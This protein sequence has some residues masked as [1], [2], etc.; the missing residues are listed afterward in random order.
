MEFM[1][2]AIDGR[3]AT[4]YNGSG[5]GTYTINL[6]NN[7][8]Y[9]NDNQYN[10]IWTGNYDSLYKKEN[11]K[12]TFCS[13]KNSRFFD[14]YYIPAL[15]NRQNIDIYHIPQNGIGLLLD[16]N[17]NTVITLHDLIPYIMPETVGRGYLDVFLKNMPNI[18][19]SS[20]GILTVSNHS[21]NDILKF[22]PSYPAERIC[23]T[24]L[25]ANSTFY[26]QDKTI[27][28][29]TIKKLYNIDS[30]YILY[31]GGFSKR[32]NVKNLILAYEKIY[33]SLKETHK[34]LI[35]GSLKDEGLAL[36]DLV[37]SKG[38]NNNIIFLGYVKDS[39]LPTLYNAC[40]AFVYPSL[41]E[42]FGLPVLEA[43][44]C[45]IPVIT[46]NTTSIPEITG[47]C[48]I[49][50][51]PNNIDELSFH[52]LSLLNNPDLKDEF[53]NKGYQRSLQFSWKLTTD[54]TI[55]FYNS[56]L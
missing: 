45:K 13:I 15:L 23:V 34:L 43:M 17:I 10:I 35:A 41:Y 9:D 8:N 4:A 33:S 18:I 16:S 55:E 20:V 46:S 53:G 40:E 7:I 19:N 28:K 36:S 5:I 31:V 37:T 2:I 49:T 21:K 30:P 6:I 3:G 27:C 56:L 32:K 11:I 12:Y 39:V 52:L 50:I 38:L 54:K 1:K 25:A 42:G 47:P 22:F 14:K 51:N 29:N 48:A 44:S 24:P 26:P